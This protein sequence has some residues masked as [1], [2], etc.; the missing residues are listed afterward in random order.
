MIL[1]T[2]RTI[3][4]AAL[5]CSLSV[6]A[7]RAQPPSARDARGGERSPTA[8]DISSE[9][10]PC[11]TFCSRNYL[12]IVRDT[13]LFAGDITLMNT[14]RGEYRKTE[15]DEIFP[16]D[17]YRIG[18]MFRL[19]N[20][21]I[22]FGGGIS[23]NSDE[24]FESN[25]EIEYIAHAEFKVYENVRSSLYIGLL[26]S[27][28]QIFYRDYYLP[29]PFFTYIYHDRTL[30]L[31]IGIPFIVRWMMAERTFFHFT[32]FPVY[33]INTDIGYRFFGFL[34]TSINMT[35]RQEK[36]LLADRENKDEKFFYDRKIVGLKVKPSIGRHFSLF[37]LCGY[38]FDGS[39]YYGEQFSDRRYENRIKS[40]SIVQF[41]INTVF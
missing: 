7:V 11:D 33:N 8:I 5:L 2:I 34:S 3:P 6:L 17:L 37:L 30:F 19:G 16:Q 9:Y 12:L 26:Y 39:Y 14:L 10:I 31:S 13:S 40:S 25:D 18:Y 41:G 24:P 38:Q 27:S 21:S 22:R 29:F 35:W 1:L 28:K 32:Y 36:Y 4:L 23:S 20:Q 15:H